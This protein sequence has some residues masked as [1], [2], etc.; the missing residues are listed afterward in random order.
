LQEFQSLLHP[1]GIMCHFIDMSDHF[2]HLD[3]T[4]NIYHFLRFTEKQWQ[5]IDNS[6]QP[7]NR[8]RIPHYRELYHSLGLH[9]L[10]QEHRPGDVEAVKAMPLADPFRQ[11]PAAEVAISHSYVVSGG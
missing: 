5:W 3:H 8:L 6:I 11:M 10:E 2:A 7:Q 4:I 1:E 9:I